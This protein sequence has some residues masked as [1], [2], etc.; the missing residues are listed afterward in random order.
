MDPEFSLL[1]LKIVLRL[2]ATIAAADAI[3]SSRPAQSTV[4]W[5]LTLILFPYFAFPA[6]LIFGRR[7]FQGYRK[8]SRRMRKMRAE[9]VETYRVRAERHSVI[10][11]DRELRDY[12]SLQT[13]AEAQFLDGNS[14]QLLES[15]QEFFAELFK[16]IETAKK[17]ILFCF[18]I[19]RDDQLGRKI[20][21]SLCQACRRGV[22]VL[23]L[24]DEIGSF[25]LPRSFFD[26]LRQAGAQVSDFH[27]R[28]GRW[29][30]LQL[31]FRNHRKL[32]VF[33]HQVAFVGGFNIGDEY[34]STEGEFG[35]WRDT[36]VKVRGPA[37]TEVEMVFLSD[38][39]WATKRKREKPVFELS[40]SGQIPVL[41]VPTGPTDERGRC[42]LFFL[43]LIA[44]A[45]QRLWIASPYLVPDESLRAALRLAALRGVDVRILIP[46]KPDSR[47][48]GLAAKFYL[49]E[50]LREGVRVFRYQKGFLHEKVVL[51]DERLSTVG[52]AN[53][54]NR[55]MRLAFE[56]TLAFAH[57]GFASQ[58]R[59]MFE[60]DF[61]DS[62]EVK[63]YEL[64]DLPP[65][66]RLGAS[67]A[68]LFSP[69]L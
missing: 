53:L 60:K 17:Q 2:L 69:L 3:L 44:S 25:G 13:I 49:P 18:Y 50:L 43:E 41:T 62:L 64:Y 8:L 32:A 52:S 68:R 51:V 61:Q 35:A 23:F 36:Q 6:Y 65:H 4:A 11:S 47:I 19:V 30:F 22:E 40:Q 45:T 34:L 7:S 24:Y 28:Q 9:L 15:G 59:A 46:E 33:D 10:P 27:T 39:V 57:P 20:R 29:N 48:V 54:D 21:D 1:I 66:Q 67:F 38:W 56:I 31:N 55:S 14:V 42:S 58:V 26:E 5:V 63:K 12:R 16:E 37:A